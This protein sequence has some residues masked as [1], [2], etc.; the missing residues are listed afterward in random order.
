MLRGGPEGGLS[1]GLAE[2][3][4]VEEGS[5]G[6]AKLGGSARDLAKVAK[7][8]GLILESSD[9]ELE[10]RAVEHVERHEPPLRAERRKFEV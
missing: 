1:L 2:K 7:L 9:G 8:A 6:K 4:V 10:R 3:P 5:N